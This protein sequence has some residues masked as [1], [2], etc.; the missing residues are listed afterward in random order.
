[1]YKEI[2]ETN[3]CNI[4]MHVL[5]VIFHDAFNGD[6]WWEEESMRKWTGFERKR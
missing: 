3:Y 4:R 2:H 6:E 5:R 1:M